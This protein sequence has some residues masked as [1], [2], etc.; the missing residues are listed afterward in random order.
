MISEP[1]FVWVY[2]PGHAIPVVAGKLT[3]ETTASGSV[4]SFA[5]GKSYLANSKAVSID[6]VALPLA[7]R[8]ATFTALHGIP[9][10]I[11]DACPD[12]WGI[13]AITRLVGEQP[14]PSGYLLLNDPGRSGSLA[15]SRRADSVPIEL[16][17]R[18]FALSELL[19]A[20]EALERDEAIDPELIKALH[21]GTGGARPKCNVVLDGAVWIGKFPSA[22]DPL[23]LSV[24]RLEHATMLLARVCGIDAAETRLVTAGGKDVCLVRRFDRHVTQDGNMS[25]LG[26]IS[27]RSVFYGD[28]VFGVGAI[29]SYARLARWLPR[30]AISQEGSSQLFRRMVFNA[31]VRNTDDHELNHGLVYSPE[32]RA[33]ELSPAY[34]LLPS[35][36]KHLISQHALLIGENADGTVENLVS[37]CAAFGLKQDEALRIVWDIS[38][39]VQAQ[40]DSVLYETGFG[41]EAISRLRHCFAPLPLRR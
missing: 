15:F 2:L 12:R 23:H 3:V 37:S 24:P 41:D 1:L 38:N 33:F 6:P 14:Y 29:G 19:A 11:L 7:G 31:A 39:A 35:L 25:R 20:A 18:E 27:A 10:V 21:P 22:D 34:D 8:I 28:P 30:Y 4:G 40:W 17:S 36:H 26:F 9:G 32:S 16:K 5:Y 13:R